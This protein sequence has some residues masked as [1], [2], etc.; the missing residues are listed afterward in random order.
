M[1]TDQIGY[2]VSLC[3]L[4]EN[5]GNNSSSN[6]NKKKQNVKIDLLTT[7]VHDVAPCLICPMEIYILLG[8]SKSTPES[9]AEP[10][11]HCLL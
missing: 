1:N 5:N 10:D 6:N 7:G 9:P 4:V 3:S 2:R 8:Y 11:L